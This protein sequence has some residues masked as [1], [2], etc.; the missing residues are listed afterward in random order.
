MTA[1]K[2]RRVTVRVVAVLSVLVVATAGC[3]SHS[4]RPSAGSSTQV[5][6]VAA[7]NFWGD[8]AKQIAGDHAVVTSVISDPNADPHLYESDVRTAAEV[9]KAQL[10][11]V[12]GLGY[13]DFMDKLLSASPN[14]DRTVLNAADVM[15]I[16]GADANPHIWYD[17]AK[18]PQVSSA[19]AAALGTLDPTDAHI[20]TGNAK[21]FSDSLAPINA[22]IGNIKTQYTGAPVGYTERVPGYLLEA[23]GLKLTTPASFAKAIEDGN[24]P[25]PADNSAMDAA[26]RNKAIKVLLFNAQVTSPATDV[27]KALAQQGGV[28][29]VGVSETLPITDKNFQAWQ[30]RQISDLTS[31]LGR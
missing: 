28:P 11:I 21:A 24:D 14:P 5:N 16:S 20:F 13:D 17:I 22:A 29:T 18:V 8:I 2:C 12:N 26:V 19:I 6:V 31:A 23:A 15:H 27:V 25:S 10:V 7:E 3:G 9:S 4:P 30:L 1:R